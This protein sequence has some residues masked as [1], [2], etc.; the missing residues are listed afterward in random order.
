MVRQQLLAAISA[1]GLVA[2]AIVG[3]C[4]LQLSKRWPLL[5]AMCNRACLLAS[6]KSQDVSAV[7]TLLLCRLSVASSIL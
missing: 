7:C 2:G 6:L 5:V 4:K 1:G 3:S